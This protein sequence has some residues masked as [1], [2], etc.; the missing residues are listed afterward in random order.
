MTILA[1]PEFQTSYDESLADARSKK[2]TVG[3]E[4]PPAHPD[5]ANSTVSEK[6]SSANDAQRVQELLEDI[7]PRTWVFTGDNLGFEVQQARRG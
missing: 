6:L 2:V 7:Q 5:M 1:A 3:E 4:T